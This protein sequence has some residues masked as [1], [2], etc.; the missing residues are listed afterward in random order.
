LFGEFS[1]EKLTA[2]KNLILT[3]RTNEAVFNLI[4][5]TGHYPTAQEYEIQKGIIKEQLKRQ[6]DIS[7]PSGLYDNLR[8]KIKIDI[9]GEAIDLSSRISTLQTVLVMISQ[10]PT[11]LRDP[12]TRKVFMELL[13]LAGISPI[14]FEEEEPEL[15]ETIAAQMPIAERGGSVARIPPIMTP[16]ETTIPTKL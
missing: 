14:R 6:K 5:K 8:P 2:I 9:T 12:Q 7:I 1:E 13:D 11:I 10:N 16:Q 4:E 3:N 15:R